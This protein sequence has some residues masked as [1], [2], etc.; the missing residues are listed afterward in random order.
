MTTT[1]LVPA[2]N[3][4]DYLVLVTEKPYPSDPSASRPA[5]RLCSDRTSPELAGGDIVPI[6]CSGQATGR[7]LI[8][9]KEGTTADSPLVMCEVEV[10]GKVLDTGQHAGGYEM[11]IMPGVAAEISRN[12]KISKSV[13]C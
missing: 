2:E 13:D 8:V 4:R 6:T 5:S 11:E 7:Y 3:L 9:L 12:V 1:F 10:F